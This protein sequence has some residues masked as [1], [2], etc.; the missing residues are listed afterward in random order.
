MMRLIDADQMLLD[1]NEAYMNAQVKV[2][3]AT[4]AVNACVHKKLI[5]LIADTPSVDPVR[6][7]YWDDSMDGI[8]PHCSVCGHSHRLMRRIL[9]YCPNCGAKMDGGDG[10]DE[11]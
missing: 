4:Y 9:P 1:E 10:A 5:Q 3:G 11:N 7:G 8:T 2:S 6:H